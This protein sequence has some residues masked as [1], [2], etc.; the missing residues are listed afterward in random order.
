VIY[1]EAEVK[2][3]TWKMAIAVVGPVGQLVAHATMDGTQ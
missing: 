3:H 2:K 1:S